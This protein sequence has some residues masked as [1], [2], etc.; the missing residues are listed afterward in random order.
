MKT[1]QKQ[2]ISKWAYSIFYCRVSYA[3]PGDE[4]CRIMA[5][6]MAEE[7]LTMLRQY[8][9]DHGIKEYDLR[10]KLHPKA[11]MMAEAI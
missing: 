6:T 8:A 5:E 7:A 11:E 4:N 3:N 1:T 9:K 2:I 10:R